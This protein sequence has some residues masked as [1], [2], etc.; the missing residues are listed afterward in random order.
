MIFFS[1]DINTLCE[2]IWESVLKKLHGPK[3]NQ[4]CMKIRIVNEKPYL[5]YVSWDMILLR[6][7]CGAEY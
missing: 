7:I 6:K 1:I 2:L 4:N 5:K 3:I